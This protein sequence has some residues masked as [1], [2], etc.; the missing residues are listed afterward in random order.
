MKKLNISLFFIAIY[1]LC[2]GNLF[3]Q[4]EYNTPDEVYLNPTNSK[5]GIGTSNPSDFYTLH[6]DGGAVNSK[7]GIYSIGHN[8]KLAVFGRSTTGRAIYGSTSSGYGIFGYASSVSGTGVYGR[9]S[10]G[11]AVYGYTTSGYGIYG[12]ATSSNGH[13][14]FFDGR[15]EV[16]GQVSIGT[17]N[18]PTTVGGDDISNYK[19][20]VEGGLLA[21][22]VRVRNDWAD[23]VFAKDYDLKP[24]PQVQLYIQEKGHLPNV[25]SE[26]DV[27]NKGLQLGEMTKIQQE[28]IEELFLYVI[29]LDKQTKAL[30]TANELLLKRIKQLEKEAPNGVK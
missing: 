13:A 14:G 4:W 12:A 1:F 7:N 29:E 24:L 15:V 21:D 18:L 30:K 20:F 23:Y 5:L 26:E 17:G 27:E 3:A 11:K 2:P 6:V 22:E 19:L 16:D 25:P 9:A 8:G 28:K 10:T